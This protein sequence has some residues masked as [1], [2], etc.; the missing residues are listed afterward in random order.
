MESDRIEQQY[1]D[2]KDLY[3][4]L[5]DH[6]EVSFAT[7]IDSAYKKVLV[8][9]SASYFESKISRLITEYASAV[10]SSD[11]RL[12]TLVEQK[13][14]KRQYHTLFNWE[15]KNANVFFA[16]LGEDTKTAARTQIDANEELKRSEK[17]FIEVGRLRNLLVHEN[18]AEYD[19]NI[20]VDEI[21]EKYR[22]ACVFVSF[23][24]EVLNPGYLKANK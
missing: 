8:L 2:S 20:T 21:Y 23:L 5:M 16:L 13:V 7:Y 6:N 9:S 24:S 1:Q 15:A 14:I 19:V 3:N 11:K 10:S 22:S 4:Y 18:F 17:D 12:V